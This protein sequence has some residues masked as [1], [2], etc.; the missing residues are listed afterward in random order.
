[1][2][3]VERSNASCWNNNKYEIEAEIEVLKSVE[4]RKGF[5]LGS[6]GSLSVFKPVSCGMSPWGQW[7]RRPRIEF[8]LSI[9]LYIYVYF[10]LYIS[11]THFLGTASFSP[12]N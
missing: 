12:A 2:Q 7:R 6:A 5:E 10:Y 11:S 1:M 9:Y 8:Y 4:G 3:D